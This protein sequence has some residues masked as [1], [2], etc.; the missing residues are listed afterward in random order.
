MSVKENAKPLPAEFFGACSR[1]GAHGVDQVPVL[2]DLAQGC[3]GAVDVAGL[4]HDRA[5]ALGV[6]RD[7]AGPGGDHGCS[8]GHG[9][10]NGVVGGGQVEG[11]EQGVAHYWAKYQ[12]ETEVG[13]TEKLTDSLN[14]VALRFP[15]KNL[16]DEEWLRYVFYYID[17]LRMFMRDDMK[18]DEKLVQPLWEIR[19]LLFDLHSGRRNVHIPPSAGTGK[20]PLEKGMLMGRV[21]ALVTLYTEYGGE[22]SFK[23]ASLRVAELLKKH[24]VI[25][26]AN[27]ATKVGGVGKFICGYHRDVR[28]D[29]RDP[30]AVGAYIFY[31]GGQ[32]LNEEGDIVNLPGTMT[33]YELIEM[34]EQDIITDFG[35]RDLRA[36]GA[37]K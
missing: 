27:G 12:G 35:G 5:V 11:Q 17:R 33:V 25:F 19:T 30:K 14:L 37:I 13:L 10:E 8:A 21:S 22:E 9:L 7:A 1:R 18:L 29:K 32:V 4:E 20:D 2:R 26:D 24:H 16:P 34:I 36:A 28:R 15:D 23:S 6:L 31:T 3:H